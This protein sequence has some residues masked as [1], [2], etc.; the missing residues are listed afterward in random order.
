MIFKVKMDNDYI[1][2]DLTKILTISS[3]EELSAMPN[4][5]VSFEGGVE[6]PIN[7]PTWTHEECKKA[8]KKLVNAWKGLYENVEEAEYE[9]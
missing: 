6:K 9:W 8:H 2:V 1:F 7:S 4:F 5:W 3:V